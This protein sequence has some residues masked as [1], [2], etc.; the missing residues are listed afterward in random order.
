MASMSVRS[1]RK[2][3]S[4]PLPTGTKQERRWR[5]R[6]DPCEGVRGR[7]VSLLT[8]FDWINDEIFTVIDRSGSHIGDHCCAPV[9]RCR[10]GV[11]G[12]FQNGNSRSHPPVAGR[13][14]SAADFVGHRSLAEY[15]AQI[16]GGGQGDGDRQGRPPPDDEQ[17]SLLAAMGQSGPR[18]VHT[19]G[20]DALEP[21]ADQIYQWLSRDRMQ[22][23]SIHEL[24]MAQG[25]SVSYA[26]LR[27][28]VVKRHLR[29]AGRTTVRMEDTPPGQVA[30][31]DFGRLGMITDPETG[32]RRAVWVVVIVIVLCHS[33][34]CFLWPMH[35]QK[36][37][38]VI[39]G[40]E[41][42]WAFFGGMPQYLV[43]DNFPAAVAGPDPLNPVLI[44]GFLEYAQHRGF[45]VDPAKAGHPQDKPKV[46]RGVP[47]ARERFFK[48]AEFNGLAHMWAK[49]PR[50][51]LQVAG[52]RIHDTIRKRPLAVFQGE[53][54]YTLLP[55]D[56]EPYE[57][58]EWPTAKVHPDHH[59]QCRQAFYSVPS[60]HCPLG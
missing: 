10:N 30:E 21:W 49:A 12:G 33:R 14:R 38:D 39:A 18:Q 48:S 1:A 15:H 20:Q 3:K 42:A 58:G 45:I 6:P 52:M 31:S 57:I 22:M 41:A 7:A 51:C 53:E 44:K 36:L 8:I 4:G 32:R 16:P 47:Y 50:W 26:S 29:K 60:S 43:I 46:E 56:G 37:E 17:L 55:W 19:P 23:S 27:R 5:T 59:I 34:H 11:P 13:V 40:L 35:Q 24:L 25:C 54:R 28:F 9:P 2:W